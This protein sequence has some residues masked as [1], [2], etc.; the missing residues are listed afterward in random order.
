MVV[1]AATSSPQADNNNSSKEVGV[2][3]KTVCKEKLVEM[4]IIT[5][6]W[7]VSNYNSTTASMPLIYSCPSLTLH[8]WLMLGIL[9]TAQ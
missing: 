6:Y 5:I 9:R 3:K 7:Q 4:S 1:R 2:H 8:P